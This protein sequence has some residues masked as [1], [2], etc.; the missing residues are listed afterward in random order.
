MTDRYTDD[1]ASVWNQWSAQGNQWTIPVDHQTYVK[2]QSG[3]FKVFLTP[4][5][6]VPSRWLGSLKG[7]K[8]LGLA[9]G[10][11]QQG[12]I[13]HAL[14]ADVTILD[15]S[16]AQLEAERLVAQREGYSIKLVRH[17]MTQPL[18]FDDGQF[19]LIFHPVSNC[20]IDDVK[21]VWRQAYRVLKSG[22]SLLSGFTNPSL[23]L[24]GAGDD[25]MRVVNKLPFS[26]RELP[27]DEAQAFSR[28]YGHQFSHS[29]EDQI[30]GQ[31]DAG[32][33][34]KGFYEDK[35]DGS[36]P[37]ELDDYFPFYAAT[38]AVKP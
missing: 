19:D 6:P 15:Y 32:F 13:F 29:W 22:G 8:I 17:D 7:K 4:C 3:D 11:G 5:R 28:D 10:G 16:T 38:W 37:E 35:N 23:Y 24:F 34:I 27:P 36:G 21:P 18:P 26:S 33:L 2:A 12:P 14:G 25:S 9:S 30:G 31:C 20:Y 1:N